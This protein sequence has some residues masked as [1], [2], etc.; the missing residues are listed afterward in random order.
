MSFESQLTIKIINYISVAGLVIFSLLSFFIADRKKKL[1]FV[2]FSFLSGGI[3]YFVY[4][5]DILFFIIGIVVLL[6][7]MLLYLFVFRIEFFGNGVQA[8]LNEELKNCRKKDII[9]VTSKAI[10]CLAIGY[11]IIRYLSG[12][13]SDLAD[14]LKE[15][16][17]G[18]SAFIPTLSD[19][20]K[21]LSTDY[22]IAILIIVASLF[23]SSLWFI[24]I[25]MERK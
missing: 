10:F 17:A 20:S 11:F 4:Y 5:S 22:G 3:F 1:I 21:Q 8:G 14:Y 6:F 16:A 18:V 9:I 24:I 19:I 2:F 12:Y 25:K 15:S 13:L 7:F 23:M